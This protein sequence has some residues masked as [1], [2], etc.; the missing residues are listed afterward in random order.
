MVGVLQKSLYGTCDAAINFQRKVQKFLRNQGF[1]V[2][3]YNCSTFYHPVK[4]LR[5]MVHGDDFI[6]S[7]TRTSLSCVKAQLGGRFE[8]KSK[9]IG[10]GDDEETECRALNR[11]MRRCSEG[12]EYEDDQR[13]A[14]SS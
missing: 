1:I 11:I 12:W 4:K 2:G 8:V 10:S 14:T 7:G 5:V 6:S 3:R 13:H 9:V